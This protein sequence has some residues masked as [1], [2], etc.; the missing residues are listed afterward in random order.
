MYHKVQKK[1][2]LLYTAQ[3]GKNDLSKGKISVPFYN[4]QKSPSITN[5]YSILTCVKLVP[6]QPGLIARI[7]NL[8]RRP[9]I[10]TLL[11]HR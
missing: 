2:A 3:Q 8:R 1:Y 11:A 5:H 6:G 7:G 10:K 4:A 9:N